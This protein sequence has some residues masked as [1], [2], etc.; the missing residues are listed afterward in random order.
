MCIYS[1]DTRLVQYLQIN[2][3]HHINKMKYKNHMTS[4]GAEK[5]FDKIQHPFMIKTLSKVGVEGTYVIKAIYDKAIASII[6]NRKTT[7]IPIKIGN[8][9]GMSA[10]TFP[11]Q[12][13]TGSPSHSNHT[14][15]RNKSHSNWKGS[16]KTVFICR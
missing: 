7:S 4:L 5:A 12:H 16:S 14:I 3:I 9:T 11:I 6:L 8:K 13:T 1:Q 10:F 2:V 15:R